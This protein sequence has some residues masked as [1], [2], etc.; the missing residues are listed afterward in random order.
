MVVQHEK[1]TKSQVGVKAVAAIRDI[2]GNVVKLSVV[3]SI[4]H[5]MEVQGKLV[6]TMPRAFFDTFDAPDTIDKIEEED[7]QLLMV[8]FLMF[9]K[10]ASSVI[11]IMVLIFINLKKI[12]QC[13][14]YDFFSK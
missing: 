8:R 9:L 13:T 3:K 6:V 14:V 11:P 4:P 12:C 5:M 10:T 2:R 7:W 1:D